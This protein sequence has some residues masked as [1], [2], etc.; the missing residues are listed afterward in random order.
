MYIHI[1]ANKQKNTNVK[2]DERKYLVE[3]NNHLIRKGQ[4]V[5]TYLSTV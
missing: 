4:V 3:M 2:E 1:S 5:L